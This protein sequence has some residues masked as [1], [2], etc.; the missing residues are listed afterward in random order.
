ME[1]IMFK[2]ITQ[3]QAKFLVEYHDG[4]KTLKVLRED[5]KV[6]VEEFAAWKT[7]KLFRG[8]LRAVFRSLSL[9]REMDIR[10]AGAEAGRFLYCAVRDKVGFKNAWHF[11]VVR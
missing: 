2:D 1:A 3:R 6:G 11:R 4:V 10:M 8:A 7:D 5:Y 9:H